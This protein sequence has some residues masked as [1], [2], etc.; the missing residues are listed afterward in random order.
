VATL[1]GD[2]TSSARVLN[3][4]SVEALLQHAD[5][6]AVYRRVALADEHNAWP[7]LL[8][9]KE[10]I[11]SLDKLFED[12]SEPSLW[13]EAS[14]LRRLPADRGQQ[15]RKILND[16]RRAVQIIDEAIGKAG[17]QYP[18][19]D[20]WSTFDRDTDDIGLLRQCSM[21]MTLRA[22]V[23]FHEQRYADAAR[24]LCGL[25]RLGQM[26]AR[27]DGFAL[28]YVVAVAVRA[29]A[30][31]NLRRLVAHRQTPVEVAKAVLASLEEIAKQDDGAA[32]TL[33]VEL[34]CFAL[35]IWMQLEETNDSAELARSLVAKYVCH[36]MPKEQSQAGRNCRN[37]GESIAKL[38][39]GHAAP[40]NRRE[41]VVL[42]SQIAGEDIRLLR[43]PYLNRH[44]KLFEATEKSIAGW[45]KSLQLDDSFPFWT[46][47]LGQFTEKLEVPSDAD[48]LAAQHA[49]REVRNPLGR[50]LA[51]SGAD[52]HV[53]PRFRHCHGTPRCH[54]IDN[55]LDNF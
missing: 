23:A 47:D 16:H 42:A 8:K 24:D 29:E 3:Q 19:P 11:A 31:G 27:G 5:P 32:Q 39:A 10:S 44:R 9:A 33:R 2:H 35:P 15:L 34:C 28:H 37:Y 51:V 50:I 17:L 54:A 25:L 49:L 14:I 48:L 55:R 7:T 41:T 40:F 20:G 18:Q 46:T 30:Q 12:D 43:V 13:D 1:L 52:T 36:D 21:L 53:S 4:T 45:P 22:K 26:L 38:L 6:E